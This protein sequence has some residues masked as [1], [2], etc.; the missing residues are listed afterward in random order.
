[1]SGQTVVP[2]PRRLG[3][4][5]RFLGRANSWLKTAFMRHK[6]LYMRVLSYYIKN[7]LKEDAQNPLAVPLFVR[8]LQKS[9][10]N[11]RTVDSAKPPEIAHSIA[12]S[13]SRRSIKCD[14]DTAK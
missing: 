1:M 14:S 6:S 5:S 4:S 3:G 9:R 11:H 10:N 7:I 2:R 12:G 8:N 13:T